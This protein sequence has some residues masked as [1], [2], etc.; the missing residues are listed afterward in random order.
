MAGIGTAWLIHDFAHYMAASEELVLGTGADY[1]QVLEPLKNGTILP[2]EVCKHIVNCYEK[3]YH[4]ITNDYTQSAINLS[5]VG[6]LI[7]NINNFATL[8]IDMI[9]NNHAQVIK[10][11]IND[12]R[13]K[14]TC[15]HF[16]EDESNYIDLRHFYSNML[17]HIKSMRLKNNNEIALYQHSLKNILENGLAILNKTVIANVAGKNLKKAGGIYIYFPNA[18]IHQSFASTE[19]A[20]CTTWISFLKAFL[21]S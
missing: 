6:S 11:I 14:F 8:A 17:G 20:Q 3:T 21:Q 5:E 16:G 18:S 19:F 1:M 9:N 10:K 15:T 2:E 4:H 13:N 7:N 12:S